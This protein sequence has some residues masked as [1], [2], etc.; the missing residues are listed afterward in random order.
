LSS[1]AQAQEAVKETCS[2][3]LGEAAEM[4]R[5]KI[6]TRRRKKKTRIAARYHSKES[7]LRRFE[8]ELRHI[9]ARDQAC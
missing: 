4:T 1:E 8:L 2:K 5:Y 6:K 3:V 7:P 9:D